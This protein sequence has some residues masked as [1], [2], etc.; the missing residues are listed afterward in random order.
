MKAVSAQD[1]SEILFR[2]K[3]QKMVFYMELEALSPGEMLEFTQEEFDKA[4]SEA[5]VGKIDVTSY[6]G[7]TKRSNLVALR[8]DRKRGVYFLSK[9]VHQ[10]LEISKPQE[11]DNS[12]AIEMVY[13]NLFKPRVAS[14]E[15]FLKPKMVFMEELETMQ[16]GEVLEFT[17]EEFDF[18]IKKRGGKKVEPKLY[19]KCSENR[20]RYV[21]I[22]AAPSVTKSY[23]LYKL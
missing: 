2:V 19:F 6:Y 1:A 21:D 7:T 5:G 17:V 15:S 9:K 23:Y 4:A 12:E 14:P 18:E 3:S 11:K 10:R 20:R 16:P 22:Q 13:D 8:S